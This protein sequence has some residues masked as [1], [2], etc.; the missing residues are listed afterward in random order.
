MTEGGDEDDLSNELATTDKYRARSKSVAGL[1]AAAAGAL[2][3]GLAINPGLVTFPFATRVFGVATV[4]LLVLATGS[5]VVGSV[6]HAR[7]TSSQV[8]GR[9]LK[10]ILRPWEAL[11]TSED[12]W[13]TADEYR[14]SIESVQRQ[15][16]RATD[17]GMWLATAAI[18]SV[19]AALVSMLLIN[20]QRE[21]LVVTVLDTS[22]ITELCPALTESFDATAKTVE[23]QSSAEALTLVISGESCGSGTTG[24]TVELTVP[25]AEILVVRPAER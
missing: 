6:L 20:E 8:A 3:A 23:L 24:A 13:P 2:A 22:P 4:V 19:I 9:A 7:A 11:F 15:I 12:E 17:L 16:M 5:F 25:R 18:F 14:T 10:K 21:L 1:T